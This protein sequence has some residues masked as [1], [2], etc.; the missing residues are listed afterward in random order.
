MVALAFGHPGSLV[1]MTM[2]GRA[3]VLVS[4]GLGP[5]IIHDRSAGARNVS[6]QT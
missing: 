3:P 1:T 6:G 4:V 2:E 5:V